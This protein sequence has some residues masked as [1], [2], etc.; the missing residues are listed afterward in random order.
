VNKQGSAADPQGYAAAGGADVG[1]IGEP[2]SRVEF[3]VTVPHTGRYLLCV[4][5]GNQTE[6]IAQQIMRIDD[7][8]WSFVSYPPTLNWGFRSHQDLYAS[9]GAGPHVITFGVSIR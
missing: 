5:Y 7:R 2:G 1:P 8:P 6:D 4:Y 3:R 9:L